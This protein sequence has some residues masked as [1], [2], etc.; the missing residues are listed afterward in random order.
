MQVDNGD[1]SFTASLTGTQ[2]G[3]Y[4]VVTSLVNAGGLASTYYDEG[5]VRT[6]GFTDTAG[7]KYEYGEN[8][9]GD[10]A[11]LTVGRVDA[12]VDWSAAAA[13]ANPSASL[14]AGSGDFAVRWVG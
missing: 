14:T 3:R 1:G 2:S 8:A 6:I 5:T 4:T 9:A 11:G 13:K 7:G 12:T 10:S